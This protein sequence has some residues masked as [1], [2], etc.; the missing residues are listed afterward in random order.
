MLLRRPAAARR[1]STSRPT[2]PAGSPAS[3][4]AAGGQPARRRRGPPRRRRRRRPTGR[5]ADAGAQPPES[6]FGAAHV[7]VHAAGWASRP[8]ATSPGRKVEVEIYG[9]AF[10]AGPDR[11]TSCSSKGRTHRRLGQGRR[12]SSG[13][14]RRPRRRGH[15][16]A[17]APAPGAYKALAEHREARAVGPLHLAQGPRRQGRRG[18]RRGR[19]RAACAAPARRGP[20]LARR[21]EAAGEVRRERALAQPPLPRAR[22]GARACSSAPPSRARARP[23][24]AP[25]PPRRARRTRARSAASAGRRRRRSAASTARAA[26]RRAASVPARSVSWS[27]VPV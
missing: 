18:L 17:Q 6:Q 19:R 26:V 9:W 4:A 13:D 2:P 23:G 25:S 8:A 24:S 22:G 11:C 20:R 27:W 21:T 1:A 5:G 3:P 14:L 7:H 16:A 15:G 12:R 10:A